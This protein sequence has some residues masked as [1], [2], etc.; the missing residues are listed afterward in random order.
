MKQHLPCAYAPSFFRKT[1]YSI[2]VFT[3]LTLFTAQSSF[4]QQW[5]ILGNESQV[6]AAP[7]TFTSIAVLSDVPYVSYKEGSVGKV[8][9]R[10][11]VSGVWE[12][13]GDDIGTNI[14]YP[15]IYVDKNN[16]LFVS[17]VDAA[18]GSRLA[19][20]TYNAVSNIWEPIHSNAAN[21]YVS[22]GTVT[23][24]VSQYSST[25][26]SSM[27]FD[28]D[29]NLYIAFGDGTNLIPYVRKFEDSVW[30]T[31]GSAPVVDS[32]RA[33]AIS[34]VIDESDVPWVT[35]ASTPVASAI[36]T[37]GTI[38]LYQCA[39]GI[40]GSIA[41]PN[42]ITG[43]SST[44]A[45]S[46]GV[47]HT[48]MAQNAAG[49]L[50]ICYFNTGNVNKAT[51]VVYDKVA[52]TWSY[53]ATLGSRD[54]PSLS[55]LKDVS[56]NLYCSFVDNVSST[57]T[58]S[59]RVF[60]QYTGLTTWRELK[61]PAVVRGV[62]EP[63]G[64]LQIAA[65][66][67]TASPLIVYTKN[68]SSGVSTPIVRKFIPAGAPSVLFTNII[69][70]FTTTT[71]NAGGNITSD[72]GQPITERGVVYG[73][74][75]NPTTANTK[76]MEGAGGTGNFSVTITGLTPATFYN[77]R[78][79]AINSGGTT[80]GNN[81]RLNTLA[82][83]DAV[84][85]APK[86][87]EFLNRGLI[88]VRTG[89]GSVYV[90][91]RM[92]GTD[93]SNI[94]FNIYRDGVLLNTTPI[95]NSTNYL[96]NIPTNGTYTIK[97]VIGGDEG[98]VSE[99]AIV[100]A[101]NQLSIPLQIPPAVA[102][103]TVAPDTLAYTYSANDCS[104]G[105]VDGDGEYEVFVK[106]APSR[107]NHNGGGYSGNQIIDC[108]KMNG[109]RLWRIN[110]GKNVNAGPHFT[111]FMVY[112]LDG[113]GKAEMACKTADG[114]VDGMGVTIGNNTVNYRNSGG[115]VQ[116]GPEFLTVFNGL[117]GAAMATVPYQ[118]ARGN[119]TDWGDNYGNR[120]DRFVSAV[121]YLDGV[122]PSL[123]IG[124]GYY[125][126]LVRAA[127]D[128]RN[129][130]LTLRWIF[131]SKNPSDPNNN[132]YSSMGNHQMTIGDVDG[133]GKD[134]IFNGSSAINDNGARLWTSGNG[135]GDALHMSDMDPDRPGQEMWQC[136]ESPGQYN[137]FGLRLNDAKTGETIFAA[138][139]TGDV[140]RALAADIDPAHRGFEMWSSSGNL[141][142]V[143][144][145]QIG[146]ARPTSGSQ[147]VN[148]LVWW[149]ADL[150]RELLDGTILDKWNPATQS[151]NRLFTIYNAAPVSSSNDTKKNPGLTADL[152]GDW[153]E[154]IILRRSDNTALILFTT[155][156]LTDKRIFTLMHDP[157]YRTA[158][159]WQNSAYNQPPHPS[160]F[161]GYD[162][163]TP[164]PPNIFLAGQ[165]VLPVKLL[166][167]NATAK[168]KQVMV[169]WSASNEI[170]AHHYVVERSADGRTF[171]PIQIVD[172]KGNNGNVNH[173]TITDF[174]PL[175]GIGYYRLK[176]VD[177]DGK[178]VYSI[179]RKVSFDK[180]KQ[181]IL[182]P[183]PASTF[184]KLELPGTVGSLNITINNVD[185]KLVYQGR[186]TLI[187]INNAINQLL[188]VLRA[189]YYHVQ[190]TNN[191]G[192]YNAQLIK[193]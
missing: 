149:D 112:D 171:A 29:N 4:S 174:Q 81:I 188:P 13:V 115:W 36:G 170:N 15:R 53:Q 39:S 76:V 63:A 126:K 176:Q 140:G 66:I 46:T 11:T 26:R 58:F 50:A 154:E 116:A 156:A 65:G 152:L 99:T 21:L 138:P 186:G 14:N 141:Y 90:G 193:Q 33:V 77:M 139:T 107:E 57:A 142:N 124:R 167:F 8:K 184:V 157:Q 129:G 32:L 192:V 23:N 183:N 47:R 131:D 61:D 172:D 17:Y 158:I 43:G 132:A 86:Q 181:L 108:Y 31:M 128:Y 163:V 178:F 27:A 79:Y 182:Y 78:A 151:L 2:T 93:P 119:V 37:T 146:T 147:A 24:A 40:W 95:T 101:N 143:Q 6:S 12:Q 173:Y 102:A 125:D 68:N 42:P 113:D 130:Q 190:C 9:R 10:N 67:D 59:A 164:P 44:T 123:I 135:H 18:N 20:E 75:V 161:L 52:G 179:I 137:G 122:R 89:A 35:F 64:N 87:M 185:G 145:G 1:F 136:L 84:V 118:P 159:A 85:T 82:L 191:E 175:N 19:I 41:V 74:N 25:P 133:D 187:Q 7:A 83:P 153:R 166:S 60:K 71:A 150:G 106:W 177:V 98:N 16:N 180:V 110:L 5:N 91:W 96:D 55:M 48:S 49:N 72:G 114:T 56:G 162:M 70:A 28:S 94:A 104:V 105:D 189:G 51:V 109:T 168:D 134:E 100:W 169:E 160:F 38:K 45:P 69:T 92:F 120:Q 148:H 165:P 97:P 103:G 73:I 62:D 30:S 3:F 80:Y 22:T 121:A 155:T 34:L 127:Y 117:T 88:A 144:N 54:S 111:Q